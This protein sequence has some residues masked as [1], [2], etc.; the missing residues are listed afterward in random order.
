MKQLVEMV[1]FARV[2]ESRGFAAAARALGMTTSAVSRSVARLE[3]HIGGRLLNRSTRALSLTELGSAVYDSCA[4]IA[5]KARE[6]ESL[7]GHYASVPNG[8]LKLSAP[9]S[10]GQLWVVPM[11]RAFIAEFPAVEV[12]LDLDDRPVDLVGES[13]DLALRIA[14]QLPPGLV[15]R[16]L[17]STSMMLVASRGYLARWGPVVQPDDLRAPRELIVQGTP[18]ETE[19]LLHGGLQRAQVRVACRL[20]LNNDGAIVA[21]AC[22]HA[23]IGL[24]RDYA[25]RPAI[26]QGLLV[27]VLPGWTLGGNHRPLG[28]HAI[29]APTRHLP[30][31]VRAFIDFVSD[32]VASPGTWC[33]ARPQPDALQSQAA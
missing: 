32:A 7:A 13:Y 14:P 12:Q 15:Q 6:V 28:I 5:E 18:G 10:F 11:L 26:R 1:V 29:Y 16:R 21:A 3:A 8:R 33:A 2:A 4:A 24:V 20:A 23:G 9:V 27:P 22:E 30:R 17:G 31:K 25:A 19:L